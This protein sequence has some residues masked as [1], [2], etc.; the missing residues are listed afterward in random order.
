LASYACTARDKNTEILL[1]INDQ[2]IYVEVASTEAS[3]EQGLAHRHT[4][5]ED[6]GMLFIFPEPERFSM[7][8]KQTYVALSVA[9]LDEHGVIINIEDMAPNTLIRH[10]AARPAKYALEANRG[11]F[12]AR[13]IKPGMPVEGIGSAPAARWRRGAGEIAGGS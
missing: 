13:G 12:A 10:A 5:E 4:L 7:W 2:P 11:W 1:S 8:M 9:F 6:S 3:R